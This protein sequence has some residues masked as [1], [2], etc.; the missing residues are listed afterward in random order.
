MAKVRSTA[1]FVHDE[2]APEPFVEWLEII[3]TI[4][5]DE[6]AARLKRKRTR[7]VKEKKMKWATIKTR[8]PKILWEF[9]IA[10]GYRSDSV[11]F[12]GMDEE[13]I[14]ELVFRVREEKMKK[15]DEQGKHIQD[16][17]DEI[18]I[19]KTN[20]KDDGKEIS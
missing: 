17:R 6:E 9:A 2:I 13:Y 12:G 15:I 7:S 20:H 18:E 3:E 4:V 14:F 19:L 1:R 10:G 5:F 11:L 8:M 16:L